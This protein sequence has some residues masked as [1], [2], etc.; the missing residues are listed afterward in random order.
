MPTGVP[1]EHKARNQIAAGFESL[2]W[3]ATINKNV[4]W[5]NYNQQRFINYIRDAIKGITEQLDATSKMAWENRI[6][7]DMMLV[8]KGGV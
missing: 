4:D 6:A 3:W 2:C 5:I 1:D 8:E 7:L